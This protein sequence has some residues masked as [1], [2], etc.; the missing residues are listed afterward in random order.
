MLLS[1]TGLSAPDGIDEQRRNSDYG[2]GW[3]GVHPGR[4]V[5]NACCRSE[6]KIVRAG[7][8]RSCNVVVVP[9]SIY[10]LFAQ[11]PQTSYPNQ[12]AFYDC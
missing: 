12:V 5:Q 11:S 7:I 9:C 3:G 8:H 1:E 6:N 4:L 10:R 2:Y